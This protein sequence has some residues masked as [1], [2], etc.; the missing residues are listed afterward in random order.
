MLP[1][2]PVISVLA[3]W[4]MKTEFALFAPSSVSVPD[5]PKVPDAD[6][7]TPATSVCPAE[8]G[9]HDT[10]SLAGGVVVGVG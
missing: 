6:V 7:Y 4:K 3:V 1:V 5:I 8:L 9:E 10:R 2:P